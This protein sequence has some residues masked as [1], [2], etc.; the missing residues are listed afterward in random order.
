MPRRWPGP[1]ARRC[2]RDRARPSA[3]ERDRARPSATE[4]LPPPPTRPTGEPGTKRRLAALDASIAEVEAEHGVI[5]DDEMNGRPSGC[6]T[7]LADAPTRA[8]RRSR[9]SASVT[10]AGVMR[11]TAIELPAEH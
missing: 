4:R 2:E 11:V 6:A 9:V 8:A 5:T 1:T 3:T 10:S 7:V